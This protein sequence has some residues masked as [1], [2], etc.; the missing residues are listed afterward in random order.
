MFKNTFLSLPLAGMVALSPVASAH[1]QEPHGAQAH[2]DAEAIY[3]NGPLIT[4]EDAL[5][6]ALEASPRLKSVIAG[7]EA[8]KGAEEQA[9]YWPNPEIGVD[10]ENIAGSGAY[11][12]MD[13]A[14]YTYGL[15]Q[16]VEIGGKRSARKGA[17]TAAREAAATELL[18]GR[19]NLER[20][21]RIAYAGV[22]AEAE[23][24]QLA[25]GQEELARGVLA[26][27]SERVNAAAEPEIQRSK[28]EVAYA[29]G[30]IARQQSER[31]LRVAKEKLSRLWGSPTLDG[32]L[33][34]A[35]FFDLQAPEAFQ[36]YREK[37]DQLP[38]LRRLA[39]VAAEKESLLELEKAQVIPDPSF[40]LGVR[41]FRDSGDQAFVFA[42]SLPLPVFNRNSGNIAR[43]RAEVSQA[44]S[45]AQ[46]AE[47]LLEQQLRE[48]W[49]QWNMSYSEAQR[50]QTDVLP[51]AEKAFRLARSGYEKGK[52][53]YLEV[54]DAQR[55]LF[56]ARAQ[57]HDS[58]T[59]YHS[60]RADVERLTN[61]TG[62]HQ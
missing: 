16:K 7:L 51:A 49:E 18:L 44:E 59:R 24:L 10:V 32:A 53:P 13:A 22:L 3:H 39:Y 28:A 57:Y 4:P 20:D 25:I 62:D 29:T 27:V 47:L 30:I 19:M 52:F 38:D 33:D 42:A 36:S 34:H 9:G 55:T 61:V 6:K 37:L 26:G 45:D 56:M 21:V 58:L 31:R 40:S 23:A 50:L 11:R 17:A 48:N 43:A 35:Y 41:D 1:A 5:R 12:G 14:E 54:L 60:A 46:Q 8:A 2:S 15:N